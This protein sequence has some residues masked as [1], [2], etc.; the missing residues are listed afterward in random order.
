ML[1]RFAVSV[2]RRSSSGAVV[3]ANK[4]VAAATSSSSSRSL[5]NAAVAPSRHPTG[6]L[7][8]NNNGVAVIRTMTT[9]KEAVGN[10]ADDAMQY[11]GYQKID[12]TIKEDATVYDAVQ[13]FA[14]FNIGCLV[15]TDD[16]G[17]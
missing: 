14:A 16:K 17:K 1:S 11:S 8:C 7:C 2:A 10:T 12:F 15:T 13:K 5:F 3:A 9:V 4:S 6:C